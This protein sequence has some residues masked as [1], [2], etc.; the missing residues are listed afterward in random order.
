MKKNSLYEIGDIELVDSSS[1][2]VAA[3]KIWAMTGQLSFSP[4]SAAKAAVLTTELGWY[5]DTNGIKGRVLITVREVGAGD[6]LIL[7][8]ISQGNFPRRLHRAARQICER[9]DVRYAKED[10]D[11]IQAIIRI[12]EDC[13]ALNQTLI[14]SAQSKVKRQPLIEQLYATLL[15][16]YAQAKSNLAEIREREQQLVASRDQLRRMSSE[17][18]LTEEHEKKRLATALHDSV[19]QSLSATAIKAKV[20]GDMIA[21][22]EGR[23]LLESIRKELREEL[24]SLRSLTFELSPPILYELGLCAAV[25]W[26]GDEIKKEGVEFVFESREEPP[27]SAQTVKIMA[28]QCMRESLNNI[29]KHAESSR[30]TVSQRIVC[31]NLVMSVRD[32]G[33]GF[34]ASSLAAESKKYSRFGL[35][36]IMER[37]KE[38]GGDLK[39]E[40]SP[41]EGTLVEFTIPVSQHSTHNQFS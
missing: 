33:K 21:D 12:S 17:L 15:E 3:G 5:M 7:Q 27:A 19:L 35:M 14:W 13:S 23:D 8:F 39:V 6:E 37:M 24:Q 4:E 10:K 29:R 28:F 41:G 11:R 2:Y 38:A 20:L 9:L 25:E 40:S 31:D 30:I 26:L 32:D 16:R 1:A 34:D 18:A 22:G 36:S